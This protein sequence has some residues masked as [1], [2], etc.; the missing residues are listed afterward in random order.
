MQRTQG[1]RRLLAIV[2]M[3]GLVAAACSSDDDG[4]ATATTTDPEQVDLIQTDSH[5]EAILQAGS[6]K[7]GTRDA[8][9][10][11]AVLQEDGTYEGFDVDFCR[12][13]GI[14]LSVDVEFVPVETAARFTA[15]QTG[16]IDL[17]SRNTTITATREFGEQADFGPV[18][19]FDGQGVMVRADSGFSEFADLDDT[20][21]C[22]VEGTTTQLNITAAY[23]EAGL[24]LTEAL[25]FADTDLV[26]EA[27]IAG[28]CEV[29]T[30]D[31]SQLAA[32]RSAFPDTEG[33]P[34]AL[35]ILPDIFSK[36]PLAPAV[37]NGSDLIDTVK[38]VAWAMLNAEELGV[39]SDNVDSLLGS[40]NAD[41]QR[42]LGIEVEGEVFNP[43]FDLDPTFIRSI[44]SE[45]GNYGELWDRHLTP[46]G[47]PRGDNELY[48]NGGLHYPPPYK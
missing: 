31:R 8:L 7:C 20:T 5:V 42:L 9:P 30:S 3:I 32:L 41:I 19:V 4:D 17:L 2:A 38:V 29:W 18:W 48:T 21:V 24:T 23:E 13:V 40:D 15:L 35:A 43:G 12:A 34:D 25:S 33:G 46:L 11:F 45:L 22:L 44:I 36:E 47:I 14:A 39:T 37:I 16:E 26:Q 1:W 10:G 27:F 6:F 28:R